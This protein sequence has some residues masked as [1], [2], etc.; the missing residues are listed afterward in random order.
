MIPLGLWLELSY[1][2]LYSSLRT[3]ICF[4]PSHSGFVFFPDTHPCYFH[5]IG[6]VTGP[7]AYV[8]TGSDPLFPSF[9]QNI[10]ALGALQSLVRW[11]G[12][13]GTG[14][15]HR[16]QELGIEQ[17][18]VGLARILGGSWHLELGMAHSRMLPW[19]CLTGS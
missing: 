17:L 11:F 1:F 12:H 8:V 19:H 6:P 15:W 9:V 2:D 4:L 10:D 3:S 7:S 18:T 13:L 5:I 14:G 16:Q